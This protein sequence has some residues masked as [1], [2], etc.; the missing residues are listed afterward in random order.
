MGKQGAGRGEQ[1]DCFIRVSFLLS[2]KVIVL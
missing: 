1:S 2:S